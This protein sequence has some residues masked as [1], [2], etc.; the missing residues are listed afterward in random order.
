MA[1]MKGRN[2][3]VVQNRKARYEY[4]WLEKFQAGMRLTGTEVKSLREGKVNLQEAYCL[5][6]NGQV[7]IK[8][9]NIAEYSQ[10]SYNNHEPQ[11]MRKL[12]LK[13]KEIERLTKGTEQAGNTIVPIKVFFN[14]NNL[15][16]LDL[17]LARGKKLHDKRDTI[18]ERDTKREM[19]RAIR[20]HR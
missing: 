3:T 4:E 11:R 14:E 15:A 17:A 6:Q 10:G 12:L 7:Y 16:K 20:D 2:E 1:T 5:V 9:M 13:R 19:D 18:K 8:D